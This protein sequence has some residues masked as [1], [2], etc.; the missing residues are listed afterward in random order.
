[1]F[2]TLALI[3]A[4]VSD[5][6]ELS[7]PPPP[8]AACVDC[9]DVSLSAGA[10]GRGGRV[11]GALLGSFA[12]AIVAVGTSTAI[13]FGLFGSAWDAG[14]LDGLVA[15][16]IALDVL[17]AAFMMPLGAWV[18]HRLAGGNGSYA[19]A[20]GGAAVS[21]LVAGLVMALGIVVALG[22]DGLSQPTE[23]VAPGIAITALGGVL[24]LLGPFV[25]LE[26]SNASALV[27]RV[28]VSPIKRG[29]MVMLAWGA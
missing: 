27:P 22:T 21:T 3:A 13:F 5:A 6:P 20:V 11:A 1:M 18:G 25:G 23:R 17:G 2:M 9:V 8:P 4:G 15:T 16:A 29:G 19:S 24:G 14:A 28:A 10:D 12:G 26:V 7:P